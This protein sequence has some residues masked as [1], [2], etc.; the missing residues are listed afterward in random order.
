VKVTIAGGRTVSLRAREF[1]AQGGE[2]RIWARSGVAYKVY[3]DPTRVLAS[4]K[5][6]ALQA[7]ASDAVIAPQALLLDPTTGDPVGYTMR[8]IEGAWLLGQLFARSFCDRNGFDLGAARRVVESMRDTLAAVH[9]ANVLV[10]DLSD[11]NVLVNPRDR[12]PALIDTDSWQTPG[13]PATAVTP[14]ICDPRTATEGFSEGS[15]WFSFAILSFQLLVGIHPFRGKHPKVKGLA[16]RMAAGLSVL[17]TDVSLPPASR[18]FDVIPPQYR[19]WYEALFV[20][21]QRE[22]APETMSSPTLVAFGP[23]PTAT[24]ADG[25]QLDALGD[26]SAAVRQ[27]VPALGRHPLWL[28]TDAGVQRGPSGPMVFGPTPPGAA[29]ALAV[30]PTT[31]SWLLASARRSGRGLDLASDR[32][33]TPAT[34]A[35]NVD[36]LVPTPDGRLVVLSEGNLVELLMLPFGDHGLRVVPRTV[37]H[38]V[39]HASMLAPGVLI[40]SLLGQTHVSLLTAPGSAPQLRIPELGG[41]QILD[42]KYERGVLLATARKVNDDEDRFKR[43]VL[44]FASDFRSYSIET[45]FV[46]DPTVDFTVTDTQICVARGR[47]GVVHAGL[48]EPHASDVE[49]TV[50]GRGLQGAWLARSGN[51]AV[52]AVSGKSLFCVRL[53][54]KAA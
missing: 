23:L 47:G 27:V 9:R 16:A 43:V 34:L 26:A 53:A 21:G 37:A 30:E 15:D 38:V 36:A 45:E 8:H 7:V 14:A 6:R 13:H 35:M 39:P 10:V 31:G 49:R 4:E 50:D 25:L 54:A 44:R 48:A 46:E 42:A 24:A 5:I 52:V 32:T 11:V 33:L 40:Q 2:G 17:D 12:T 41:H 1:V 22:A 51:G 3:T 28:R 29:A 20:H 18:G 19:A